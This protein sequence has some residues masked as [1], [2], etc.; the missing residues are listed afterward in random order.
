MYMVS[1]ENIDE[2]A[3]SYIVLIGIVLH[4]FPCVIPEIVASFLA[5]PSF[6]IVPYLFGKIIVR[7]CNTLSG[8]FLNYIASN[9]VSFLVFSWV[10]GAHLIGA[11]CG[12]STFFHLSFIAK[13][14]VFIILFIVGFFLIFD[15][16][17][18]FP[19]NQWSKKNINLCLLLI[20]IIPL[21]L[22]PVAII[23]TF[24]P[25]PHAIFGVT[26]MDSVISVQP[27]YRL[28]ESG[29]LTPEIRWS[30]VV[31]PYIAL[32]IFNVEPLHFLWSAPFILTFI[33][34]CGIFLL[35]QLISKKLE[36]AL[37]S[38]LFALFI[39]VNV[40]W[41]G[42]FILHF[43]DG[44][45]LYAIFPFIL[46]SIYKKAN[47]CNQNLK[48]TFKTLIFCS[49]SL[50]LVF[51]IIQRLKLLEGTPEWAL[52]NE[53]FVHPLLMFLLPLLGIFLSSC[54]KNKPQKSMFLVL[55]FYSVVF[56][57]WHPE[58]SLLF[59]LTIVIFALFCALMNHPR[60]QPL[61]WILAV[62]T[63]FFVYLQWLGILNLHNLS[64]SSL[65]NPSIA[66]TTIENIFRNQQIGF[67]FANRE[68]IRLLTVLG[69]FF[70]LISRN[71]KHLLVV[72][73]L[74]ATLLVFFLPEYWM[75]RGYKQFSPFMAYIVAFAVY[76]IYHTMKKLPIIKSFKLKKLFSLIMIILM[77][78]AIVSGLSNPLY[79]AGSRWSNPEYVAD[80]EYEAAE[81]I[82]ANVSETSVFISDYA[83]MLIL[84]SLGNKIWLTGK[85]MYAQMFGSNISQQAIH[86]IKFDVFR[87][88]SSSEAYSGVESLS[89]MFHV[90]EKNYLDYKELSI[91]DLTFF[92]VVSS[93]TVAWIE[94]EDIDDINSAQY[95]EVP[96]KYY[97]LF[98]DAEYFEPFYQIDNVFYIYKVKI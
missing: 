37:L 45:I 53:F 9:N 69:S 46:F 8:N 80:Y 83:T 60:Y 81:W 78:G 22:A 68:L 36:I 21:S 1:T 34:A 96:S 30:D 27:A 10:L 65:W 77:L 82:K 85:A 4:V 24:Q 17:Q 79:E 44:Q 84:N 42:Q 15:R 56:F 47:E 49:I 98:N 16:L 89:S 97:I 50:G 51:F 52:Y 75:A 35:S 20:A 18:Q 29:Y 5:L 57:L 87:T 59:T 39:N 41:P 64:I 32:S 6:I 63:F 26:H 91:E 14:L 54:I 38:V 94:Q 72:G 43:K 2:L 48:N 61:M 31:F 58:E 23:K 12:L 74:S 90:Q 67:S 76:S 95:S 62:S 73:M 40:G 93:R 19:R 33:Y 25:F 66:Q 28:F 11:I 3:F 92:V 70:A 88:K 71:K 7:I 13:N 86:A 55:F